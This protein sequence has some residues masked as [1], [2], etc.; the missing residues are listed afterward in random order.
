[1]ELVPGLRCSM[2][3]GR[4]R[5]SRRSRCARSMP[6]API[7]VAADHRRRR[8]GPGRPARV[9]A[10]GREDW[11]WPAPVAPSP[12]ARPR[13]SRDRSAP[14]RRTVDHAAGR[15]AGRSGTRGIEFADG[16]CFPVGPASRPP[17]GAIITFR[18]QQLVRRRR[19]VPCRARGCAVRPF[20]RRAPRHH[21]DRGPRP[22]SPRAPAAGQA[23]PDTAPSGTTKPR[24]SPWFS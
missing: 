4:S 7:R 16:G 1:M 18:N 24:L 23:S 22:T 19:A 8:A 20:F 6:R 11:C 5:P 10:L 2:S 15:D 14:P 12:G 3:T 9:E 17:I 21:T 13:C